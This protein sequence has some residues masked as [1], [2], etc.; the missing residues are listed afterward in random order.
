MDVRRQSQLICQCWLDETHRERLLAAVS[1]THVLLYASSS[2]F[3]P[4]LSSLPLPHT[5]QLPCTT[6]LFD[7]AVSHCQLSLRFIALSAALHSGCSALRS[8]P[9]LQLSTCPVFV[10][11]ESLQL[12]S[13][14]L[15]SPYS[16]IFRSSP[17][18]HY[19]SLHTMTTTGY[20][21]PFTEHSR[22]MRHDTDEAADGE[23]E[24]AASLPQL[25][26]AGI[27]VVLSMAAPILLSV[28]LA[29]YRSG[30]GMDGDRRFYLHPLCM[31]LAVPLLL[32]NGVLAWRT[33][34]LSHRWRKVVHASLNSAAL[35]LIGFGLYCAFTSLSSPHVYTPHSWMGL[36]FALLLALQALLGLVYLGPRREADLKAALLPTHA[37]LGTTSWLLGMATVLVGV[38]NLTTWLLASGSSRMEPAGAESLLASVLGIVVFAT[39]F[40]ALYAV[41]PRR[42]VLAEAEGEQ[43][44]GMA[45]GRSRSGSRPSYQ[46][47]SF[48][49]SA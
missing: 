12:V 40:F 6:L 29:H 34:P 11:L 25:V 43:A 42:D 5:T 13:K 1:L 10:R 17:R 15:P 7:G 9:L 35:A 36:A 28:W 38:Q 31:T 18:Y 23:P 33:W 26:A 48:A 41:L 47:A 14:V 44:T 2:R 4:S 27:A 37:W 19:S 8:S 39:A 16:S 49:T 20:S 3:H 32:T 24:P 45:G 22:V 30:F 46:G 21:N